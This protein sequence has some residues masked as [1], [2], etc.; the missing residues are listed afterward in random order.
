MTSDNFETSVSG[1]AAL[2]TA[3]P[4]L[5]G[6][7]PERSLVLITF[8]GNGDEIGT[9]MRHDLTL[10]PD[11]TPTE[12]ML[13]VIDHLARVCESYNATRVVAVIIDDRMDPHG[14]VYR[15]LAA[16]IDRNLIAVGGLY[17][18]FWTSAI[19]LDRPWI[20][21]WD[22][23][24][25]VNESDRIA[26]GVVG[27]PTISPVAIA[28]AV[29]GGRRVLMTRDEMVENL[30]PLP[31]CA[32]PEC[33][34]YEISAID[35]RDYAELIQ[36]KLNGAAADEWSDIVDDDES[37]SIAGPVD[38]TTID[39][40]VLQDYACTGSG[41]V[42]LHLLVEQVRRIQERSDLEFVLDLVVRGCGDL[43]CADLQRLDK[44]LRELYVRD[45]LVSLAVTD[46]W[47]DAEYLFTQAARRLRGRGQAAAATLLG[48]VHYVHGNGAMAGTAFDVALEVS[49][50]YSMA[51]LYN[52]ALTRGIPPGVINRC[53][54]TGYL[55]ARSLG[56][57]LPP[58]ILRPAA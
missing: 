25:E 37:A 35:D 39:P 16:V 45:A 50:G 20:T 4:A 6:F 30:S 34:A 29:A 27:D 10:E 49:P 1:P 33:D 5:L 2:I 44:A 55:V 9:T 19:T 3:I 7:V 52:D 13:S 31:H 17:G 54:E 42:P 41:R 28:R 43:D 12:L 15:R 8:E 26:D 51:T 24:S 18:A 58:P 56:V 36:S 22:R 53:A 47:S 11:G 23:R 46:L 38:Q 14:P 32:S 21:L 57:E 48:F 40:A